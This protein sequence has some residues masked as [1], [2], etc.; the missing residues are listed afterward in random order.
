MRPR[1][2]LTGFKPFASLS[3]NPTEQLMHALAAQEFV[4]AAIET[5]VLDVDYVLA[6]VQFREAVARYAPDAILSFGVSGGTDELCLERIAVN[7]DDAGL[8]DNGG[9]TR[10]GTRIVADG[11]VGYWATLD[12]D[13]LHAALVEAGLPVR[14]SNHA[15]AYL[16]NHLFY[17]GLHLIEVLGLETPM[18][19][20]HVP[21]LPEQIVEGGRAKVGMALETLVEA[22][23]VCVRA[24][25]PVVARWSTTTNRE[26]NE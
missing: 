23:R 4:D 15:G 2:L 22:A 3:V 8:P 21:P 14:F 17:Y 24:I 25:V 26:S 7:V 16:C 20:V 13:A 12:L 6:E 1:L 11:P 5:A 10:A 19:F 18:G 9:Q